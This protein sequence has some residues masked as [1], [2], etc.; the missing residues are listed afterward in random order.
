MVAFTPNRAYP[1]STPTDPADIAGAIQALAES[2]D[3]DVQDMF[4][5]L[6]RRPFCKVRS[7]TSVR[8]VFPADQTTELQFDFVEI[9][10]AGVS[11]LS[12]EPTRLTPTSAGF[13]FVWTAIE[14]PLGVMDLRNFFLRVNGGDLTRY[15]QQSSGPAVAVGQMMT[16][17]A[18]AFMD[19]VNDYFTATFNPQG[20]SADAKIRNK[21]MACFQL[22]TS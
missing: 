3:L 5:T 18:M 13:W 10:T 22:T 4:D 9:D 12:V 15:G 1:Y 8:Q 2:I 7:D 17:G 16:M 11:N 6:T 14:A 20:F 19:G 21:Q